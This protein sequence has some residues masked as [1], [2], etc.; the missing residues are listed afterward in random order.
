MPQ[1]AVLKFGVSAALVALAVTP[2][3]AMT[4]Q[5]A[6][7]EAAAHTPASVL[8]FNQKLKDGTVAIDYVYLPE[9]GYVAI[10]ADENGKRS[11]K[12]LGFTALE[13]GSHI[14][15]SVKVGDGVAPGSPL[16]ASLYK[17]VDGDQL[18]DTQKDVAFWPNGDPSENQFMIE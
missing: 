10:F 7:P 18:L 11:G 17:D 13:K 8:A 3:A 6:K 9:S 1:A 5:P 14:N 4:D 12:V 2:A 16:W 15:A